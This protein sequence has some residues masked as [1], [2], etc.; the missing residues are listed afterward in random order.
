MLLDEWSV[1]GYYREVDLPTA[2]DGRLANASFGNGVLVVSLPLTSRVWPAMLALIPL[3]EGRGQ[4]VGS[5]GHPVHALT[6]AEHRAAQGAFK[7]S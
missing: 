7:R 5:A 1:G 6:T 3:G 2:V 4:R